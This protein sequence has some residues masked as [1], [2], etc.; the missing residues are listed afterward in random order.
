KKTGAMLT[1][2]IRPSL[3]TGRCLRDAAGPW[4]SVVGALEQWL[5]PRRLVLRS[6]AASKPAFRV[7]AATRDPPP[8]PDADEA[9]VEM[10]TCLQRAVPIVYQRHCPP[11]QSSH[12]R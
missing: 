11:P 1:Y 6:G 7:H 4:R 5:S 12:R 2:A 9:T 8:S 3:S 10:P